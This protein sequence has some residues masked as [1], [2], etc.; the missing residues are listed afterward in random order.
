VVV[1]EKISLGD[2]R[3]RWLVVNFWLSSCLPCVQE[4]G[5]LLELGQRTPADELTVVLISVDDDLEEIERFYSA[6]RHLWPDEGRVVSL[7]DRGGKLARLIGTERYPE[8]YLI[9]PEGVV[10][11]KAVSVREWSGPAARRCFAELLSQR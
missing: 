4:M 3:G 9:D 1:G 5:G 6:H 7:W 11:F 2:L 10:R 8:T